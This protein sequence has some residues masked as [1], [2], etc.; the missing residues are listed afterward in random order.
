MLDSTASEETRKA[1]GYHY[2]TTAFHFILYNDE[3]WLI[4]E[5]ATSNYTGGAHDTYSMSY[6]NLDLSASKIWRLHDIIRDTTS[7]QPLINAAARARFGLAEGS[8][9]K[10]AAVGK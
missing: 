2:S 5:N 1:F 9:L 10:W 8:A 4:L 7:L 6:Q 3:H